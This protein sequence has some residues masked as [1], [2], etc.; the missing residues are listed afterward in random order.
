MVDDPVV[1]VYECVGHAEHVMVPVVSVYVLVGQ[2]W[3]GEAA[4]M[5]L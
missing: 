3:Q 4:V 5:F 2:A 1:V